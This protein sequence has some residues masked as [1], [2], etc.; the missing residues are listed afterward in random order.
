M[1]CFLFIGPGLTFLMFLGFIQGTVHPLKY[2]KGIV[3]MLGYGYTYA[4]GK[5]LAPRQNIGGF[6]T[7]LYSLGYFLGTL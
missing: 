6:Y 3:H 5:M 1:T 4:G 7:M 2:C